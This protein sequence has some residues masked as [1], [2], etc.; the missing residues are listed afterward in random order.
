MSAP[1]VP[2]DYVGDQPAPKPVTRTGPSLLYKAAK[3]IASLRLTVVLFS[4]SMALVFLGTLGMTQDSIEGTVHHYFRCWIAWIDLQGLVEFGKVFLSVDKDAHI[5]AKLP[6]PGGYTIGWVMFINLLAAHLVRFKLTWKRSGIFMLH[7]GVIVLLA[8]EFLTG[9]L[10]VETQMMIKEGESGEFAF[11]LTEY[12]LAVI[13]PTDP[14]VDQVVVVPGS[15]LEDARPSDWVSHPDVPFDIQVKKYFANAGLR[16]LKAGET[17]DVDHGMGQRA[18]LVSKPKVKGTDAEGKVNLP[19]AYLTFRNK[20]GEILGTYLFTTALER[21]QDVTVGD[22]TYQVA[23][24]FQRTY[25][26]YKVEVLKTE[27]DYYPGTSIPKDYA[28]TVTVHDPEFG[29]HGPIRIWMNHPMYYRGETF[30]QKSMGSDADVGGNTTGLQVVKNT[31]WRFPYAACLL[32]AAG[33]AFHFLLRLS[34]FLPKIGR[35]STIVVQSEK[36]AAFEKY[37]PVGIAALAALMLLGRAMP[38][39]HKASKIDLYAFGQIPVQSGGRV[40]PLD[41]VARNSLMVI[42][43]KQE[44]VDA[45]DRVYPATEWLLTL[46]ANPD[47]ASKFKIFR[48]DNPQLLALMG[49]PQRPGS[50]RYSMAELEPGLDKLENQAMVANKKE[51]EKRDHYDAQVMLLAS[52]VKIYRELEVRITP[53]FMTADDP[54]G[55]WMS[56]ADAFR[57]VAEAHETELRKEAAEQ[58]RAQFNDPK[59]MAE[60]IQKFGEQKIQA[61]IKMQEREALGELVRAKVH[62]EMPK[63]FPPA[64]TIEKAVDAFRTEKPEEFNEAVADYRAQYTGGVTESDQTKVRLEAVM[65]HFDPFLQCMVLYIGVDILA[66]LSWLIWR[67]PLRRAAF[68]LAILTLAVHTGALLARMYIGNRPPVTN[69]YSSAIF[70]GWGGLVLCMFLEYYYKLGV[71]EFVGGALGF[72]TL[73][74]ARFLA[75]SGDTLE[76]L[77]AVLDTNFWLATH[78]TTVTLGYVA[79]GVAGTIASVY[80]VGGM[81]TNGMRGELGKKVAGMV[82]GTLCFATL[83]SFTGTVLGGIWADQS[84]GRFWGWD[85]KENGAVLIVIWNSLILHARWAGLVKA[86]GMAVLAVVGNM[87]TAW[88]WFGT[89]QLGIGLHAYGF[90]NRLAMGCLVYWLSQACVIGLGLVPIKYWASFGPTTKA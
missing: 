25:K 33:M 88:S 31:A 14:K 9:Q 15:M 85:P 54:T 86:R 48:A 76:M 56:I 6:F 22:K 69:L 49:L 38:P 13:D 52:H 62:A 19:G 4:L 23:Y 83:L 67:T 53:G 5:S 68:A 36:L 72:G 41:S 70:I 77:Q 21:K 7:A 90:D 10:S 89:N 65:N 1:S 61:F 64:A 30:Y 12:E 32:V 37:F 79:T 58:V 47:T 63:Q 8:G 46:W 17:G 78:V 43:G 84:W 35:E 51:K 60:L 44:F 42:S 75:E 26:P 18:A 16:D 55:K 28:S 45:N 40:Q 59:V 11:S 82:Y 3:A 34:V 74:I 71:G 29:D 27:H 20:N 24:R 73:L 39:S 50:Y 2:H 66:A 80:V 57:K 87:V 81:F